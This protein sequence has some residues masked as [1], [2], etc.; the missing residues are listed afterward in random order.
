MWSCDL[1]NNTLNRIVDSGFFKGQEVYNKEELYYLLSKE[2]HVSYHT[3]K[4]WARKGSSGPGDKKV[5]CDLKELLGT[6]MMID[7]QEKKLELPVKT[8]YSEFVKD[9]IKKAYNLMID[10][11][12]V[13]KIDDE[14]AYFKMRAELRKLKVCIPEDIFEKINKCADECLDP[15][16]Y[17]EEGP[18]AELFTEELGY[19]DEKHKFHYRNDD[20]A[21]KACALFCKVLSEIQHKIENFAMEELYPILVG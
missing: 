9:N 17:Y 6:D 11:T 10:Y 19:F 18:F 21:L 5:L 16:F 13:E 15:I 12:L 20:V 14:K 1:Y 7:L 8:V 4:G 3:V 2:L